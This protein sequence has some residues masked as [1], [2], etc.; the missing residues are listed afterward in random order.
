MYTKQNKSRQVKHAVAASLISLFVGQASASLVIGGDY[1][2]GNLTLS[3]GDILSGSFTNIGSFI[4]PFGATVYVA[5]NIAL[6]VSAQ[7][8]TIAGLLDGLGAGYA[9]GLHAQSGSAGSGP[10]GGN[11][12]GFGNA[13]HASGGAG[14][15]SVGAGGNSASYFGNSP[16][17]AA[18]GA[19]NVALMGSGGGAAGDHGGGYV[20]TGGNGGNGGAAISLN[21]VQ[22]LYLTGGIS[23]SGRNGFQGVADAFSASGGGGGAGGTINLFSALLQLDGLLDVWGGNGAS[24]TNN[25]AFGSAGGGGSGG[26]ILLGGFSS[27]GT[28]YFANVG[29]GTAGASASSSIKAQAGALGQIVN[30]SQALAN[31]VPEPS[32]ILLA[33]LGLLGLACTRAKRRA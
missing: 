19:A 10:G 33:G 8:I 21:G 31:N 7:Q 6:S 23:A 13:V 4:I 32:S 12:G 22:A 5:N 28:G 29:G 9:G 26:S 14:G 25:F 2:G 18:G 11:G 15:G 27:F 17:P 24:S 20:G 3:S 16:A 1:A 30:N